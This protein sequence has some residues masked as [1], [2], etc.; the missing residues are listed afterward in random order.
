MKFLACPSPS[1]ISPLGSLA[2]GG[3]GGLPGEQQQW[4]LWRSVAPGKQGALVCQEA[5][6]LT[7]AFFFHSPSH[8][9]PCVLMDL[10]GF[11][12]VG[13]SGVP[14][15]EGRFAISPHWE[16]QL[17]P[18]AWLLGAAALETSGQYWPRRRGCH[19]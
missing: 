13:P 3:G 2:E 10:Q 17:L 8:V 14:W 6:K 5:V 19:F 1:Y 11:G 16:L 18:P 7:V 15:M 9:C 12:N 4:V